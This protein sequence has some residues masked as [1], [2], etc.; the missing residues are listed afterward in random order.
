M[1]RFSAGYLFSFLLALA[2]PAVSQDNEDTDGT[3]EVKNP[4][5]LPVGLPV[6]LDI[7]RRSLPNFL[8][9]ETALLPY[10]KGGESL[11]EFSGS[12]TI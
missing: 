12:F 10:R 4:S 11:S 6:K 5:V 8:R 1:F 7:S 3:V 2:V 9:D